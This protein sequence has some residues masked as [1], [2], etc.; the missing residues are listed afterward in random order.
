MNIL[1]IMLKIK[2]SVVIQYIIDSLN[3]GIF[4]LIYDLCWSICHQEVDF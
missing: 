3:R 2:S 4:K 1:F